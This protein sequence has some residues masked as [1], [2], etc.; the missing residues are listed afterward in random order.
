[1]LRSVLLEPGDALRM[2]DALVAGPVPWAAV[3]GADDYVLGDGVQ[4]H[5]DALGV[6]TVSS[7]GHTTPVEDPTVLAMVVEQVAR[8]VVVAR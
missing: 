8:R 3:A 7:G 5:L 2:V 1:M 6:L 4:A